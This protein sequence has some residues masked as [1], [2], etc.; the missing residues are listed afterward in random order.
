MLV[1][2]GL[3]EIAIG[4]QRGHGFSIPRGIGRG[5]HQH[6]GS[7]AAPRISHLP[8]YLAA[9][10]FRQIDVENDQSRARQ[11]IVVVNLLEQADGFFAIAYN[12]QFGV[13]I[14]GV[15]GLGNK[16]N[17]GAVVFDDEDERPPLRGWLLRP[18]RRSGNPIPG[19]VRIR[20]RSGHGN[21][22][23]FAGR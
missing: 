18:G 19:R 17:V 11:I 2:R 10:L 16:K 9:V 20:P 4:A 13:R 5:D 22:Q 23:Q 7:G 1:V 12:L 14:G 21:V 6:P 8:E 3:A 15:D